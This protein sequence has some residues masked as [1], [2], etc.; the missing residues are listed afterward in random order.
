[1]FIRIMV[2]PE[3]VAPEIINRYPVSLNTDMWNM[4]VFG[5]F[6]VERIVHSFNAFV[7]SG[8]LTYLLLGGQTPFIGSNDFETLQ[9]IRNGNWI[10]GDHFSNITPDA[11]DFI[12]RLL[13]SDPNNRLTSEQALNHPWLK[14]ALQHVDTTPIS[15]DRLQGI[16]SRQLY[17]VI[18][19]R[20]RF[21][22]KEFVFVF[23]A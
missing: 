12:S 6:F 14:Y 16:Y 1:M 4:Y 18:Y 13:N 21:L 23:V 3:Y 20:F 5:D 11:K 7:F 2:S 9:N 8:I 19:I 15:S 10:F 17:D 22:C